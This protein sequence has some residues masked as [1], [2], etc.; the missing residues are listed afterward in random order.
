MLSIHGKYKNFTL[1]WV[2]LSCLDILLTTLELDLME[3]LDLVHTEQIHEV[4]LIERIS[5]SIVT[6]VIDEFCFLP[7]LSYVNL[8]TFVANCRE[9]NFRNLWI[10]EFQIKINFD[11]LLDEMQSWVK[12]N[13]ILINNMKLW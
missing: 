6:L 2:L 7:G 4:Y 3:K 11:S 8:N 12:P 5:D 9:N 13:L 1:I 10:Q